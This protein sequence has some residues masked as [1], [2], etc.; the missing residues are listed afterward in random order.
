MPKYR[1]RLRRKMRL[2]LYDNWQE[3]TGKYEE[4]ELISKISEGLSFVLDDARIEAEQEVYAYQI[5]K[6]KV[7]S[8]YR[9][10]KI[11]YLRSVG[12]VLAEK[13]TSKTSALS[14]SFIKFNNREIY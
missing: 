9:A 3:Q 2:R 8:R 13:E 10:V 4:G 1:K 5:W 11:P 12:L 7:G 14:D 6:V